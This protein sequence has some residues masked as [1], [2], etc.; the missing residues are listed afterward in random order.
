MPR[1]KYIKNAKISEVK[2]RQLL[3]IYSIDEN[4]SKASLLVGVHINTAER[5]FKLL[6]KSRE[7]STS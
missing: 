1:N 7:K 5:I 3:K 6:E 4:A 2:F